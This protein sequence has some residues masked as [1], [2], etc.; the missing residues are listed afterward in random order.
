MTALGAWPSPGEELL[1]RSAGAWP[2]DAQGYLRDPASRELRHW[3]M[4]LTMLRRDARRGDGELG[5]VGLLGDA[6]LVVE[7]VDATVTC[8]DE[9]TLTRVVRSLPGATVEGLVVRTGLVEL[10]C[11][12]AWPSER[13]ATEVGRPAPLDY[14]AFVQAKQV[15]AP[16]RGRELAIPLSKGLFP[17][18]G[19]AVTWAVRRGC[20]ALFESFGLGKT[21]QELEYA[22]QVLALEGGRFLIVAPLGVRGE[23]MRE[24]DALG[25]ELTFIQRT[26]SAGETG[27]YL[28]NY[29]SVREGNVDPLT[30]V[31]VALDEASILRGF[32]GTKTFR[33]FMGKFE[34]SGVR[35]RLVATATPSPNDYEELLA[36]AAFLDVAEIADMKTRFFKRDSTKADCLT[37]YPHKEE[38]FFRWVSTWALF[39]TRP[40]DADPTY[41]DEGYALPPMEVTWHELPSDHATAGVER[42]GQ[43]RLLADASV[44][45]VEASREKRRSLDARVARVLEIVTALR[46]ETPA[47]GATGHAAS[48]LSDQVVIWCDLNDE[49]RAIEKALGAAGITVSSMYG[50]DTLDDREANIERWR[51]RETS[52]FLS[53]PV[54]YGAGV[55]LQQCHTMVFAGVGYKFQDAFQG[56]HRVQRFGQTHPVSIHMIYTESERS[57]REA[58]AAKWTNHVELVERMAAMVRS[59]GLARAALTCARSPVAPVARVEART[60]SA[61]LVNN[62]NVRELARCADNSIGLY[63][64]S[65]PYGNQYRYTELM[66]DFGHT[67]SPEHFF[68]QMDFL[69][70]HVFRTLQPGRVLA[71]HVK[72][73]ITPGGLSGMGFRT[74]YPFHADCI[75]NGIKHGFGLIGMITVI[76]DVVRENNQTNRLGYSAMCKDSSSMGV[77]VPEHVLIFRKPQ[78]DKSKGFADVRVTRDKTSYPLARW[79]IVAN[80]LWGS[81]GERV[82]TADDLVGV[83]H[84]TM[85]KLWK[86]SC[87]SKRYDFEEHVALNVALQDRGAL[88]VDFSLFPVHSKHPDVWTDVTR[89]RTSNSVLSAKGRELHVCPMQWDIVDRLIE[90]YSNPGDIVGDFFGGV[91][92]TAMRAVVKGRHGWSCELSER[93]HREAVAFVTAAERKLSVPTLFDLDAAES[94]PDKEPEACSNAPSAPP[95]PP[96]GPESTSPQAPAAPPPWSADPAVGTPLAPVPTEAAPEPPAPKARKPR[97]PR[98]TAKPRAPRLEAISPIRVDDPAPAGPLFGGAEG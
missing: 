21:R 28:T 5:L 73:R 27:I 37:V 4:M 50:A 57:I 75:A 56:M 8:P 44:G 80:G 82:L 81:S 22:R 13:S 67:D 79:Q 43:V 83:D 63:V 84:S 65:Y 7:G 33:E 32:G 40:S 64:T 11:A 98:G 97:A 94:A 93:Y 78:T 25:L 39:L 26:E 91:G 92:T 77:G 86:A 30:F 51:S 72:D 41:S 74:L 29:E 68:A 45:I 1:L 85:Y 38:E 54:M 71:V 88:P 35:Y 69:M 12:S 15:A 16:E 18:Q 42:S 36:Y 58:F 59:R 10:V 6:T 34:G 48:G 90:Q 55:N 87:L 96:L 2:P 31:G 60:S 46:T 20:A 76:T 9:D 47:P 17:F 49:Q 3:T 70:P 53:K 52:V 24:A 61:V 89:M 23:F 19:D 14:E 66:E 95:P 62:D